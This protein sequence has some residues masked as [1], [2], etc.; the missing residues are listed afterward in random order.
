VFILRL[1]LVPL[2][3]AAGC[4]PGCFLGQNECEPGSP[5]HC[6]GNAIVTCE[7]P[8][9]DIGCG[10]K[11]HRQPCDHVCVEID[12]D[13]P[14]CVQ[15]ASKDSRCKGGVSGLCDHQE[16]IACAG[17]YV[18]EQVSC[19]VDCVE[20][21]TGGAPFCALS[22]LRDPSCE[23]LLS[24]TGVACSGKTIVTCNDGFV[25]SRKACA[26]ACASPSPSDTFCAGSAEPDPRCAMNG[27]Q[28]LHCMGDSVVYCELGYAR[29]SVSCA[30]NGQHCVAQANGAACGEGPGDDAGTL[31]R[32]R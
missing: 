1:V 28:P 20:P 16:L 31:E 10:A 24:A 25:T 26:Q 21:S 7:P 6:E 32:D 9:S 15:S 23:G 22:Q 19:P 5:N 11:I 4:F 3:F 18:R 13:F 29:E 17:D 27:S 30:S 8:C 2:A 14:V 12:G